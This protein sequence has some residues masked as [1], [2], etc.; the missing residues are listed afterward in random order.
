MEP[1]A[2]RRRKGPSPPKLGQN[3]DEDDELA[4]HPQEITVRRDPDIQFVLKRANANHKLQATMAHIIEK[5]SRDFEG[6][7]DE[8]DME[9]GEIVVNNGHLRNMRDEGDVEG[10]WMDGDSNVDQDEGIL[11]ED[12]TDEY[13]DNQ[14]EMDEPRNPE[15]DDNQ[16]SS[17]TEQ[18]P[19]VTSNPSEETESDPIPA[20]T[21][22][23]KQKSTE[24]QDERLPPETRNSTD[25]P[26]ASFGRGA[27][28]GYGAPP[29]PFGPW[30]MMPGFPMN[31]WGRDDIPPYY[32]MPPSMPGPWF[33]GGR[34]EFPTNDGQTSI[35]GRGW[36]KKT[37]RAGFMKKSSKSHVESSKNPGEHAADEET[38][39]DDEND[40]ENSGEQQPETQEALASDRTINASDEDDDLIFSGTTG[41]PPATERISIPSKEKKAAKETT[42]TKAVERPLEETAGNTIKAPSHDHEQDDGNRRRSGRAR[43]PVEYMGKISWEEAREWQNSGQSLSVELHRVDRANRQDFQ[44]VDNTDDESLPTQKAAPQSPPRGSRRESEKTTR[45]QVIPDSQDTATP[46]NSSAPQPSQPASQS[47]ASRPQ[48][49]HLA[50]KQ[51]SPSILGHN[52]MPSMTLSDDEAPLVLSR[53]MVPRPQVMSSKPVPQLAS[54]QEKHESSTDKEGTPKVNYAQRTDDTEASLV[55]P[56]EV[57]PGEVNDVARLDP[58]VQPLKR[59]RGRPRKSDITTKAVQVEHI[60]AVSLDSASEPPKRKRGRPRRSSIIARE[61]GTTVPIHDPQVP[62]QE[63]SAQVEVEIEAVEEA[64]KPGCLS[65]ELRWLEKKKPKG[66]SDLE[67]KGLTSEK[68][69]RSR[70]SKETLQPNDVNVKETQKSSKEPEAMPGNDLLSPER[71]ASLPNAI[72]T[73]IAASAAKTTSSPSPP[74]LPKVASRVIS[75]AEPTS[76]PQPASAAKTTAP[77]SSKVASLPKAVS[78]SRATPPSGA[79]SPSNTIPRADTTSPPKVDSPSKA[80]PRTVFQPSSS[81]RAALPPKS[82]SPA[83]AVPL[84]RD[85]QPPSDTPQDLVPEPVSTPKRNK[86]AA[87]HPAGTPS[88]SFKP[89]TPRHT[90]IRTTRAPSSRRS[91]LSFVSDSESDSDRSRDELARKVRLSSHKKSARPSTHKIWKSTSLTTEVHRT[92]S[93]RRRNEPPTPVKTPGGTLRTCGV[94]GYRCGREFCFT[95]LPV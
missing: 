71:V 80:V 7:G 66:V 11:L 59:K 94:D 62:Q 48:A 1:P 24:T 12:L 8:I 84:P 51:S 87:V 53:V 31:P 23:E 86:Y 17:T 14:D 91:L 19:N 77:P 22:N 26:P 25:D 49:S 35:W 43:K 95:C 9:T 33:N 44:S 83:K 73:K 88:N 82:V 78:N 55:D 67:A 38:G 70:G 58:P 13:S 52:A 10:L 20:P 92:P 65:R 81:P 85:H 54:V 29:G 50:E 89:H 5:Y 2:K 72:P 42:R 16:N 63:I 45:R 32:N 3:D 21:G 4:S 68:R 61:V 46:F 56:V 15:G 27:P 74:S 37:K 90:S 30:S 57:T 41:S 79:V 64:E 47:Q 6:V 75:P 60:S 18:N 39:A 34:Y 69:L 28:L 40:K 76:P 36:V 93:R